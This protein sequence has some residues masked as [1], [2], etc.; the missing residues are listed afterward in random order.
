MP[1]RHHRR[2]PD[3]LTDRLYLEA[4]RWRDGALYVSDIPAD[5]VL[6]VELDGGSTVIARRDG[7]HPSG[8]GWFPDGTMVVVAVMDRQ[9]HAVDVTDAAGVRVFADLTP[10]ASSMVNDLAVDP[11]GHAYI[12]MAGSNISAGEP[13]A[14]A[15]LLRVDPDGSVHDVGGEL[16][17][18][19]GMVV[20]DGHTLLVAETFANRVSAFD[21]LDDGSLSGQREWAA[22]PDGYGPDGMCLDASGA[23][24][25]ACPFSE[26]FARVVEGGEI[27]DEIIVTG[28]RAIACTLGGPTGTTFFALTWTPV[29]PAPSADMPRA[30]QIETYE[31]EI[32]S[33]GQP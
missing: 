12:G 10:V 5:E 22:L 16:M 32:G 4:P 21:I 20:V 6:R 1:P 18:A 29:A 28:R 13:I 23:V 3:L 25:V 15:P 19:N 2:G 7:L 24:W 9:L 14:A 31:V 30:S 33:G 17:C 8:L 11:A 26:R 27:T